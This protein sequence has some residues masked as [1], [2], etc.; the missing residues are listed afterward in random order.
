M[1]MT[2]SDSTTMNPPSS[3]SPEPNRDLSSLSHDLKSPLT[4]IQ[5]VLHL[6]DEQ[7]V[8]PLNEKQASMVKSAR[9]DCERLVR[10]IRKYLEE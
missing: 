4:G 10:T 7:K 8:G 9:N 5:M 2:Y 6:L 1:K 3:S